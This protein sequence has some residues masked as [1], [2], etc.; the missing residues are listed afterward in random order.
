M[1]GAGTVPGA[2]LWRAGDFM[3]LWG[4]QTVSLAGQQV[5]QLALPLTA[6]LVLRATPLQVGV[7][8]ACQYLP[9][10]LV[11]LPVG[12]WADRMRRRPILIVADAARAAILLSVP[13]AFAL[14]ILGLWLLY[15]VAFAV[16]IFSVFF[17]VAHQSY[18]PSL[19]AREQL[20]DGNAKLEVSYQ[21]ATLAGPGLAGVLV[22]AL[23]APVAILANSASFVVSAALLLLIRR[24]E[25]EPARDREGDAGLV[26]Q[27]REG[28]RYVLGHPLLRPIALT[29]AISNLF[30]FFGIVEAVLALYAIRE[31]HVSPAL[32][33]VT[34]AA[35][36][37][38]GVLGAVANRRVVRRL[39]TGPAIVVAVVVPSLAILLLAAATPATAVVVLGA[40]L[41]VAW[42]SAAV[43]NVN[44]IS[45]RQAITPEAMQGRMNATIR[46]LIWGTIPAGAL[47]GGVLAGTVGLRPA[48]LLAG[49]LSLLACLPVALSP[50]RRL[51][52]IPRP[53]EQPPAGAAPGG[54]AAETRGGG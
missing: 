32:L 31:L 45:L 40:A 43:Y 26:A 54:L 8:T 21:G 38:G 50:V 20:V 4:A 49:G 5:S 41:V 33:G 22:Q 6:I 42:F 11:G 39:G 12:V 36:N 23:T 53:D 10:L 18:L 29:T 37:V 25:P 51:R 52:E 35:G 14:G 7:L 24:R 13:A 46:F 3:K 16:G 27:V 9:F 19:V 2:S 34:L 30:G 1:T 47:L 17:D 28:L 44:Q 48:L 15:P